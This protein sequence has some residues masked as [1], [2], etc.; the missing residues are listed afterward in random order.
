MAIQ[1]EPIL[2]LTTSEDS[3]RERSRVR[4]INGRKVT[5]KIPQHGHDGAS[6]YENKIR[7]KGQRYIM[8]VRHEGHVVPLILTNAAAHLT[9]GPY[10]QYQLNKARHF[11]WFPAAACPCA[12]VATNELTHDHLVSEEAKTGQPCEPGTYSFEKPCK[13]NLAERAARTRQWNEDQNERMSAFADKT[14][15]EAAIQRALNKELVADVANAVA[16]KV[17]GKGK[18]KVVE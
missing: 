11:G 2:W 14:E 6:D 13:H 12:L 16:E 5:E 1:R 10:A 4:M 3:N 8:V 9:M 7:A 18:G 15:K 17:A